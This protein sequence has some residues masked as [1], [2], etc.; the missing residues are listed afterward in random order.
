M[1]L[2]KEKVKNNNMGFQNMFIGESTWS[3]NNPGGKY[4]YL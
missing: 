1:F 3:L 4:Y 2:K